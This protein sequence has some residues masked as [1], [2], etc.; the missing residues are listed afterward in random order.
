MSKLTT[1]DFFGI[2]SYVSFRCPEWFFV[3]FSR[4]TKYSK[5]QILMFLLPFCLT[6]PHDSV[7]YLPSPRSL[8][9]NRTIKLAIKAFLANQCKSQEKIIKLDNKIQLLNC[10]PFLSL[11]FVLVLVLVLV[12]LHLTF[13]SL[14]LWSNKRLIQRKTRRS[15]NIFLPRSSRKIRNIWVKE[16]LD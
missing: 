6:T 2:R 15:T 13:S 5:N 3:I 8:S 14:F 4:V 1:T 11:L 12:N 9:T 7:P 10:N 16:Q